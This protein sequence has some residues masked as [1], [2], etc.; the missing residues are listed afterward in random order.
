ME[1]EK[2]LKIVQNGGRYRKFGVFFICVTRPVSGDSNPVGAAY[3]LGFVLF[4][5][6]DYY[7]IQA[8]QAKSMKS[9]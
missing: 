3:S 2:C 1:S 8:L 6:L 7:V 4:G 9:L 5:V